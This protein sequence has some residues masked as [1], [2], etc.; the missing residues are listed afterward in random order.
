MFWMPGRSFEVKCVCVFSAEQHAHG[1]GPGQAAHKGAFRPVPWTGGRLRAGPRGEDHQLHGP[2]GLLGDGLLP[3]QRPTVDFTR[4][5]EE[6]T[7]PLITDYT[8]K[9]VK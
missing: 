9:C 3:G 1:G 6:T 5:S 4:S 8:F 2:G 7:A